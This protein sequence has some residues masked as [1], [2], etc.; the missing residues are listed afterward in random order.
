[1]ASKRAF[2]EDVVLGHFI[3]PADGGSFTTLGAGDGGVR[4]FDSVAF[5]IP[6]SMKPAS[7]S[8]E[9]SS[10]RTTFMTPK[11]SLYSRW[12]IFSIF[13]LTPLVDT[14]SSPLIMP[15]SAMPSVITPLLLRVSPSTAIC[16]FRSFASI[17][18]V[19]SSSKNIP[20]R[21]ERPLAYKTLCI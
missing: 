11:D 4:G 5:A 17:V 12:S 6:L 14:S 3:N 2:S 9:L 1:M 7:K 15:Y 18:N 21:Y 13:T 19:T 16:S 10:D 8:L 20:H